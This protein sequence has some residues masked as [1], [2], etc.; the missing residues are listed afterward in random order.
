MLLLQQ[1]QSGGEIAVGLIKC[2]HGVEHLVLGLAG[3]LLSQIVEL[4]G[5]MDV[6]IKHILQHSYGLGA[7]R[8][9]LG[10]QMLVIVMMMVMMLVI[11]RVLVAV[12]M[13]MLVVMM[14]HKVTPP[15]R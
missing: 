13:E 7:D 11:V 12:S 4:G 5:M 10:M 6:M 1:L 2:L 15:S 14:S 3:E 9:A 8:A